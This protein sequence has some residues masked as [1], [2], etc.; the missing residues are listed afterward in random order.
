MSGC[1]TVSR[2]LI[3]RTSSILDEIASKT[4]IVIDRGKKCNT[5]SKVKPVKNTNKNPQ[6]FLKIS[7]VQMEAHPSHKL[8]KHG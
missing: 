4:K 1:S 7:P 8:Q 2:W 5:P 6:R 3:E